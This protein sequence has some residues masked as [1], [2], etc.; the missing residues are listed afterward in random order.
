MPEHIHLASSIIA[1]KIMLNPFLHVSVELYFQEV[2]EAKDD[3]E[4]N[5]IADRNFEKNVRQVIEDVCR[6]DVKPFPMAGWSDGNGNR[7]GKEE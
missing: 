6:D 1:Q 5:D 3:V 7:N 2:Y 4:K